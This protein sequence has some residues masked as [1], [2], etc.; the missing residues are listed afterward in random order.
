MKADSGTALLF[1]VVF[2][3][4]MSIPCIG[5]GWVGFKMLTQLGRYPSRTPAIQMD[6][7]LKLIVIEVG[8]LAMILT[9]FKIM[10]T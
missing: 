3:I 7:L 8:S 6:V 1:I 10:T 2:Y 5:I 4:M 9:F